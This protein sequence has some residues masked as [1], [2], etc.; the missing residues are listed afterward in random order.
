MKKIILTFPL[1]TSFALAEQPSLEELTNQRV[2]EGQEQMLEMVTK[3]QDLQDQREQDKERVKNSPM[4]DSTS[5]DF[6]S[7]SI[8]IQMQSQTQ[9]PPTEQEILLRKQAVRSQNLNAIQGQFFAK[10]YKGTE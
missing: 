10:N 6:S 5:R 9:E 8:P 3:I 7:S 4:L 2:L 1:L